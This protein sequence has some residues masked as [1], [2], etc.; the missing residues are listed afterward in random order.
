M[1][2]SM[3]DSPSFEQALAELETILR[4]LEDGETTLEQSLSQYE[5]GVGLLRICFSQLRD[6]EQ[7]V[8]VLAGVDGDGQP[9]LETFEHSASIETATERKKPATRRT[10]AE[11]NGERN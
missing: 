2:P 10:K 9:I 1:N 5:R 7:R 11:G 8:K 6:A 3:P 4:A